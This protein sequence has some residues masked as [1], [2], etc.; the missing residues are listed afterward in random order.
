MSD[1]GL[2]RLPAVDD[3]DRAFRMEAVLP[4]GEVLPAY[5]YY[6]TGLVLNQGNQPHCVGFAWRQWLTS[7]LT[8]NRGGPDAPSIYHAA[9]LIDEW[10]GEGYAGT[11]VRAGAKVLA[12]QGYVAEYRWT[13]SAPV[14]SAWLLSKRGPVVLGTTWT[15][16]MFTPNRAGIIRPTG[17]SVGGHAY[18]CIGYNRTRGA[19]RCINSWGKS[20]GQSGRFW[21]LG[22]DMQRLLDDAGECC[23]AGEVRR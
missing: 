3:R 5:Y 4:L 16:D 19:F 10:P 6:S 22:E 20:W 12:K 15:A 7:G 23:T 13:W 21:L 17:P 9:Q 14:L 8:V 2:G 11:S 1:Y 18:L